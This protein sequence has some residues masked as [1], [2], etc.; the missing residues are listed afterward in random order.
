MGDG[1]RFPVVGRARASCVSM[2]KIATAFDARDRHL[3][4]TPLKFD[5]G[6]PEKEGNPSQR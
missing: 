4:R 1:V 5:E 6:G 2:S 3:R